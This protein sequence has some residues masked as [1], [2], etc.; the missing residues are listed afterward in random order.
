MT[1]I[2][3]FLN[4]V[5]ACIQDF[6]SG[7]RPA[8]GQN[9]DREAYDWFTTLACPQPVAVNTWMKGKLRPDFF[10][11]YFQPSLGAW[12]D[13][14]AYV[15]QLASIV[16]TFAS[17]PIPPDPDD[18]LA[19]AWFNAPIAGRGT[20]IVPVEVLNWAKEML[21][22]ICKEADVPLVEVKSAARMA[23]AK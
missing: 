5:G 22:D 9:P 11:Y 8:G 13:A 18:V 14:R 3:L 2:D 12:P 7:G 20:A 15:T 4:A 19:Q 16:N 1:N 6:C 21:P 23:P 10:G 17:G